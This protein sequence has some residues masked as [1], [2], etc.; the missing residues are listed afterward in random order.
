MASISMAPNQRMYNNIGNSDSSSMSPS[1]LDG[2]LVDN[3]TNFGCTSTSTTSCP[4][5]WADLGCGCKGL[6]T[7]V[8]ENFWGSKY[9]TT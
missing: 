1:N 6:F 3:T 4:E 9:P 8:L 5:N 2:N 7:N